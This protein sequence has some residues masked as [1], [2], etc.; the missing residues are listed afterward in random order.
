MPYMEWDDSYSVGVEEIDRQHRRLFELVNQLHDA[1]ATQCSEDQVMRVVDEFSDY[2]RLH[3][4]TEE[5]YMDAY[6]YA[7]HDRHVEE[8]MQCSLRAVEFFGKGIVGDD[9]VAD[10]M[11]AFLRTWLHEHILGTDKGLGAFLNQQG[12]R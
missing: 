9:A 7:D 3:F 2:T 6:S 12:V 10:E 4:A 8:H 11:L 5:K 1:C